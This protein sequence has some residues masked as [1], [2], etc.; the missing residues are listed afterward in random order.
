MH[1]LGPLATQSAPEPPDVQPSDSTDDAGVPHDPPSQR[2]ASQV[3]Y[4]RP[5]PEQLEPLK[6]ALHAPHERAPHDLPSVS[7]VQL[8]V[9]SAVIVTHASLAQVGVRTT[10][11]CVPR[12]PHVPAKPPHELQPSRI[13]GPHSIPSVLRAQPLASVSRMLAVPQLPLVH[14]GIVTVRERVPASPHALG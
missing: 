9:S 12:S 5:L 4:R 7:R 2:G 13:T 3:R 1:E 14:T 6:H 10:R 8:R 11:L